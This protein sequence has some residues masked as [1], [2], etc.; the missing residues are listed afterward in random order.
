MKKGKVY[1]TGGGCGDAGLL[2]IKALEVLRRCDVAVYDSLVSEE[3]LRWT[4]PDCEKIFVGKRYSRHARPQSEINALLVEKAAEGRTVVRLKGGDPY[5][6]GRGGEEFLA[7]KEAGIPCEEISGISSAI[8]APASAGIPVTYR[9]IA[10]GVTIVTGTAADDDCLRLDFDTLAR[11]EGTLVILMGMHHLREIAEGLLAAGKKPDTPC[12][13]VMEG[14]TIRQRC[15]RTVLCRLY[16]EAKRQGYASPAVIVVGAVA[17]LELT[18]TKEEDKLPLTGVTVGVTGTP[19]FA[20]RMAAALEE[21]GAKVQDMSFLEVRQTAHPLP[22]LRD[23]CWLVFTSP[24]GVQV[25]LDKMR[26]ERRDLRNLSGKKIAVIGPGTA[27]VLEENGIYAD[28]MPEIYD[29]TH[30]A[31]GLAEKILAE[32]PDLQERQEEKKAERNCGRVIFL[33]A[34]QGSESLPRIFA[35]KGIPFADHPL[36]QLGICEEKRAGMRDK[37]PDYIVFG[38]AMGVRAYFE[39]EEQEEAEDFAGRYVC[40]G[41]RCGEELRKHTQAAF[42][43][44]DRP[45][46]EA[47]VACICGEYGTEMRKHS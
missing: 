22:D 7:L 21:A 39:G 1:L 3:L 17:A 40:I 23:F 2:T 8:A 45:E 43:V 9:G 33:R 18:G 42:L 44:A 36:Y 27:A 19:H 15:M 4:R 11:L 6:F 5:V 24:N 28:Y 41:E 47:V 31:Q 16:E 34:E 37:R 35:A 32:R 20:G 14:T 38:S 30:L 25:F 13:I 26:Q 12:A 46:I 29:G 10:A